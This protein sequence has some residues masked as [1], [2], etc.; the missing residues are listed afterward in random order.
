MGSLRALE[1]P[2]V[3]VDSCSDGMATFWTVWPWMAGRVAL[4]S[5]QQR[6]TDEFGTCLPE[7]KRATEIHEATFEACSLKYSSFIT[8]SGDSAKTRWRSK[9]YPLNC[10]H[11][12]PEAR[13]DRHQPGTRETH[14][15]RLLVMRWLFQSEVKKITCSAAIFLDTREW[16]VDIWDW[17]F[18][19]LSISYFLY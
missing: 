5:S 8:D 9:S 4:F 16:N 19:Q 10:C 13:Q 11:N 2:V 14:V 15:L 17:W 3:T 1:Q 7:A 18:S 12:T 6:S